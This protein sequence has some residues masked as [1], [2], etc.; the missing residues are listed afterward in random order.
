[1]T[2]SLKEQVLKILEHSHSVMQDF[3]VDLSE[4]ERSAAGTYEKWCA[5]DQV[6]HAAFWMGQRAKELSAKARGE[7]GPL[8]PSHY[9]DANAECFQQYCEVPWQEVQELADAA[10]AELA[11]F[12]R[13]TKEEILV[14]PEE[15]REDGRRLWVNIIGVGYTHPLSH[16][17]TYFTEHGHPDEAGRLWKEWGQ[18]VSPLD[19]DEDWQGL[20]SYNMACSLALSGLNDQAVVELRRAL[21]LRPSLTSWSRQDS[22]LTSLHAMPEYRELYAPTHWWRAIDAG[23][24]SE[25]LAD[26]FMRTFIMLRG[27]VEAFPI[28]EWRKG[29]T[30]YQRPVGLALHALSSTHGYCAQKPGESFDRPDVSWEEK[31]SSKLPSQEELLSYLDRVER[32]MAG[33]LAE[34]DLAA[35][36]ELFRW[37]GSTLFSR[38]GYV[39]RHTQ[40]HLA[41]MCLELHR[42]GLKAPD[43][44]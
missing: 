7:E 30:P 10:H 37:T 33:F 17:A 8:T 4:A 27:A 23:P 40:H 24:E 38:A 36:E 34:A 31:D 16:L 19:E 14:A 41:E 22:D 20:V 25:A 32:A 2:V 12:V 3:A 15:D 5:K 9:E 44:Q 6:A 35:A 39:L 11:E 28:E 21:K 18:L 29:D 43:W 26:Q 13:A 1:V 42:R